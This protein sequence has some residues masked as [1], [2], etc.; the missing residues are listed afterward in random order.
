MSKFTSKGNKE[1]R[2]YNHQG[3]SDAKKKKL[4]NVNQSLLSCASNSNNIRSHMIV[5]LCK[6]TI[7]IHDKVLQNYNDVAV[8]GLKQFVVYLSSFKILRK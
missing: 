8:T 6:K 1:M 7:M 4:E 2:F 3:E 5:N